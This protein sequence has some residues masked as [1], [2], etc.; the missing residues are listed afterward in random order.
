MITSLWR[1]TVTS[2][3]SFL[4]WVFSVSTHILTRNEGA[5]TDEAIS[6]HLRKSDSSTKDNGKTCCDPY[7]MRT[8]AMSLCTFIEPVK[9]LI[10]GKEA[11]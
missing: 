11:A 10:I 3:S 9:L 8:M 1:N 5:V 2:A 6:M 7:I 4:R